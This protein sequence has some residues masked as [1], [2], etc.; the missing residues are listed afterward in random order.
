MKVKNLYKLQNWED[1]YSDERKIHIKP[2]TGIFNSYD[3]YLCDSILYRYLPHVTSAS[4]K[5]STICEIGSG[6]GKLVKKIAN[7]LGYTAYGIEFAKKGAMQGKTIGVDTMIGDAFSPAVLKKYK[8]Y[9]DV[10]FSYGFIEHIYPP[11]K[12]VKLHLDLA[13]PGGYVVIQIPRFRGFNYWKVKFF[14]SELLPLHN[15]SIMNADVLSKI[16]SSKGMKTIFCANYG[17]VKLRL[18]MD[19]KNFRYYLLKITCLFEYILNPL[20]RLV[21]KDKGYETNYFSPAVMFIGQKLPSKGKNIKNS[22]F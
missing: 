12:A 13:K 10:V 8:H 14:R 18:P 17:T 4:R 2:K 5:K 19:K 16:C 20:L 21:Y 22:N 1:Y 15:L 6:D 11:E 9:F 7:M 3:I